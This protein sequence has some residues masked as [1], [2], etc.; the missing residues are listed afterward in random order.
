MNLSTRTTTELIASILIEKAWTLCT[1]ES[2]TG[3]MVSS[4]LTE[5]SGSSQWFERGYVTYSNQAKIKDIQVPKRLIDEFGAVSVE[6]AEAMAKGAILQT[7]ATV[8]LAITGVAGPTGGTSL[9]PVGYVCFAWGF[10][11]NTSSPIEVV[12][13]MS[14]LIDPASPITTST[15]QEI[16]ERARDF[17]L[18]QLVELLQSR[19]S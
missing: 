3:G 7:G 17:A 16:R 18:S 11:K 2:C 1:A 15:R 13:T 14:Q 12:A 19:F 8:S 5:L 4:A 10:Q 6:V 9:K